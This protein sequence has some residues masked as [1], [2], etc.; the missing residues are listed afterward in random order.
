MNLY[1]EK[2]N[3]KKQ[4]LTTSLSTTS[5]LEFIRSN[6]PALVIQIRTQQRNRNIMIEH[7]LFPCWGTVA[8]SSL[9]RGYIQ[10]IILKEGA[11]HLLLAQVGNLSEPCV[12]SLQLPAVLQ[13]KS[14]LPF[15]PQSVLRQGDSY[16]FPTREC[17]R[18]SSYS[19]FPKGRGVALL[20]I[21]Q[22]I[23]W[24][25]Y[26]RVGS[27]SHRSSEVPPISFLC[28]LRRGWWAQRVLLSA[29]C[30]LW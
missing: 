8:F 12:F 23:C 26:P 5:I 17:Q 14:P 6:Y 16:S 21:R 11:I 3:F 13:R 20:L 2:L 28:C 29:S 25:V 18:E 19:L 10:S 9:W 1:L 30:S 24:P 15:L 22:D 27:L 4:K 7:R